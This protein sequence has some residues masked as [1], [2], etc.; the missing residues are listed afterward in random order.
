[1]KVLEDNWS[2]V[3]LHHQNAETRLLGQI[4]KKTEGAESLRD[5]LFN[6]TAVREATKGTHINEYILVFTVMTIIYLP[7]GFVATLYSL[8]MFD[9]NLPGQT[10]SFTGTIVVVSVATYLIS[11]GL[12]F[13][14]RKRRRDGS[15]R[16]A[17]SGGFRKT[18]NVSNDGPERLSY[19]K[20]MGISEFFGHGRSRKKVKK[21]WL[22]RLLE[23][24]DRAKSNHVQ[25]TLILNGKDR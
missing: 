11:S 8:D 21:N 13:G 14:V 18:P 4:A 3:L 7:L 6:A 17:M 23:R 22:G 10:T 2:K 12:L 24:R 5:G 16:S 20:D 25:E 1:M 15:L 9:F 19:T